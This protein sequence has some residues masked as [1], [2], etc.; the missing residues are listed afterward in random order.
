[1]RLKQVARFLTHFRSAV[2]A[3]HQRNRRKIAALAVFGTIVAT[4][5]VAATFGS[6]W[7]TQASDSA[8]IG[9]LKTDFD[10]GELEGDEAFN[11]SLPIQNLTDEKVEIEG[12]QTTCKCISVSPQNF[13]IAPHAYEPVNLRIEASAFSTL[14]AS[15]ALRTKGITLVA[16]VKSIRPQV[17]S[18]RLRVHYRVRAILQPPVADFGLQVFGKNAQRTRELT[19]TTFA[20]CKVDVVSSGKSLPFAVDCSPTSHPKRHRISVVAEE[21]IPFGPFR[22]SFALRLTSTDFP[23][24]KVVHLQIRGTSSPPVKLSPSSI[25]LGKQTLGTTAFGTAA[26]ISTNG[27]LFRVIAIRRHGNGLDLA[28]ADTANA[29]GAKIEVNASQKIITQGRSVSCAEFLISS[30]AMDR[31]FSVTLPIEY[32]GTDAEFERRCNVQE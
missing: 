9:V 31:P 5:I 26:L 12:F 24:S 29:N 3:I 6:A 19:L 4:S 30:P 2:R 18:F 20:K 11:V 25:V 1:M 14:D 16:F 17:H 32:Y 22:T 28:L 7:N 23:T 13:A 27:D 21:A 8:L 10:L 15:H